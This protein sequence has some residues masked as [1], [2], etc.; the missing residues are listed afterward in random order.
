MWV[1]KINSF[2]PIGADPNAAASALSAMNPER[3][4]G[5]AGGMDPRMAER[6]RRYAPA[7]MGAERFAEGPMPMPDAAAGGAV[8]GT[9]EAK[10]NQV[11]TIKL[12]CRGVS[13]RNINPAA[14]QRIV[15]E[16]HKQLANT[17]S[18]VVDAEGTK[19]DPQII[20]D[21]A[22]GTFTFGLTLSLKRPLSL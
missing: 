15:F 6:Y 4:T 17:N 7:P 9:G 19:L 1:E 14:D 12:E 22:T 8:D 20:Q 10:T 5:F 3:P 21:D 11:G 16:F 13:L 18:T 2:S